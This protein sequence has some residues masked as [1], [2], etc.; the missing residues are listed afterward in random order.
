MSYHGR[1]IQSN[2]QSDLPEPARDDSKAPEGVYVMRTTS[3]LCCELTDA[4]GTHFT[5]MSNGQMTINRAETGTG[6]KETAVT[7]QN[8]GDAP[9]PSEP[10][11]VQD[12][13]VSP[14]VPRFFVIHA[15]GTGSELLRH[16]D[17][18]EFL[19]RAE[20]DPATAVLKSPLEGHPDVTGIT[21]LKPYSGKVSR[22]IP[23]V[24]SLV[25]TPTGIDCNFNF[26]KR[27]GIGK[28]HS[29]ESINDT[30]LNF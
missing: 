5:V 11:P 25:C 12:V 28:Y 6:T 2:K 30:R 14:L 23:S 19:E 17:V 3:Q 8:K 7:S 22:K 26:T 13:P 1:N 18:K 15:D 24:C 27:R 10:G 20:K 4:K 9:E 29:K 21:V 16:V